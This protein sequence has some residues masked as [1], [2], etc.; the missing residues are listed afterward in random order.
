MAASIVVGVE[1]DACRDPSVGID[2]ED[3]KDIGAERIRL[4]GRG[5]RIGHD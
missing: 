2:L 1:R 3:V 4:A 5:P